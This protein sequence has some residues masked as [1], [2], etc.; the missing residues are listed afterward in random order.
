MHYYDCNSQETQNYYK[1]LIFKIFNGIHFSSYLNLVTIFSCK[2]LYIYFTSYRT[3]S[4]FCVK[5]RPLLLMTPDH[6]YPYHHTNTTNEYIIKRMQA[7][8]ASGLEFY[9]KSTRGGVP[10]DRL[11][12]RSK[13][14]I[15]RILHEKSQRYKTGLL[16]WRFPVKVYNWK[17][18]TSDRSWKNH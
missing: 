2:V 1:C 11:V 18:V 12:Q 9:L 14:T 8:T 15:T 16:N 3:W 13:L 7:L 5:S 4:T 6:S 10:F 17:W